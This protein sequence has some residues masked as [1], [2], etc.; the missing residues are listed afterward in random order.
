M[1]AKMMKGATPST[2]GRCVALNRRR[3][4]GVAAAGP[5]FAGPASRAVSSAAAMLLYVRTDCAIPLFGD[6]RLG[7]VLLLDGGEN[8]L[9]VILRRRQGV[10]QLLRDLASLGERIEPYRVAIAL[11]PAELSFIG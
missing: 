11:Q 4:R 8:R 10:Q 3:S 2:A 5:D 9:G 6:H 7:G 1:I